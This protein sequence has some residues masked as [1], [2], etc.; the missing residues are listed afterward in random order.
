MEKSNEVNRKYVEKMIKSPNNNEVVNYTIPSYQRGYRWTEKEVEEF[1][2]DI[3]KW[4]EKEEKKKTN[5]KYFLQKIEIKKYKDNNR[6]DIVDGQQRLTTLYIVL[7]AL[8]KE[9]NFTL[10][11]ETRV[12]S[13]SVIGSKEFLEQINEEYEKQ[14]E[15]NDDIN[16]SEIKNI[17]FFCFLTTYKTVI[18]YFYEHNKDKW[19]EY[20]KNYAFFIEYD[21]TKNDISA[22]QT[23]INLNSAKISLISSEKIKGLLLKKNN[24]KNDN[25]GFNKQFKMALEWDK[26][27]KRLQNKD[28]WTWLGKKKTSKPRI[29]FILDIA[30]KKISNESQNKSSLYTFQTYLKDHS[31]EEL[32]QIIKNI[33]MT[34]E[35]WYD[36]REIRH[37][38][39]FLILSESNKNLISDYYTEYKDKDN[40]FS[41][42]KFFEQKIKDKFK[43]INN[44]EKL[45]YEKNESDIRN[46][47]LLFNMLTCIDSKIDFDFFRHKDT[48]SV[49]DIEHIYPNSD[50]EK[51]NSQE[52]RKKWYN[53]I[54]ECGRYKKL[55]EKDGE[56][57]DD[58]EKEK[59]F[60]NDYEFGKLIK[61]VNEF[62]FDINKDK[63]V[64][65]IGGIGNLCLLDPH[66]NREY[67]N[68][69]FLL[70]V[71]KI[72]EYDMN[73]ENYILPATRNV[74]LK[75]YS[76]MDSN[77][78][79]WS[80]KD[81]E[82]YKNSIEKRIKAFIEA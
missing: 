37:Y 14:M 70:K 25:D 79:V 52:Q 42:E 4:G 74:F 36:N 29:D 41:K 47:L 61:K 72:T 8:G 76:D 17:D 16:P 30:A 32:W 27:E 20:L 81:A 82:N 38:L 55:L 64:K 11:Y 66:T 6:I 53:V 22:E 21:V 80:Q 23:F 40:S 69:V 7:K 56:P 78:F 10:S 65:K 15:D 51:I 60:N 58:T 43:N 77:N 31:I 13:D 19:F 73:G 26:I 9:P 67:G 45:D 5:K 68:T 46:Y 18:C 57:I 2:D 71:N 34:I 1:L 28:F 35:D 12:K 59:L 44:I 33:F 39:G 63:K 24:F 62:D 54:E 48:G 50:A 75:Y 49:Y 3:W